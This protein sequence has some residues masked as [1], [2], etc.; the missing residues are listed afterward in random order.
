MAKVV[1]MPKL[2]LTMVEGKVAKW[3]KEE[4][5]EVKKGRNPIRCRN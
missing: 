2:G 5:E 4:G 3:H 1:V